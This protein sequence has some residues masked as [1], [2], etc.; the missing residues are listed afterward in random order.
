[1]QDFAAILRRA[2]EKSGKSQNQIAENADV[3]QPRLNVFM[4]G[5]GLRLEHFSKLA[6]AMG[7]R[8][9]SNR[10]KR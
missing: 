1:M 3:P 10:R 2:I 7:L 8:L 5:G 9:T 6:H 4:N